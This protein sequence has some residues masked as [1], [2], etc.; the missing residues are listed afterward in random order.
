MTALT[1]TDL[2]IL[3]DKLIKDIT[4]VGFMSKSE[5]RR[6]IMEIYQMGREDEAVDIQKDLK[7]WF[8]NGTMDIEDKINELG[9]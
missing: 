2:D 5:A 9:R 6:R 4:K 3:I 8:K 7:D 1:T